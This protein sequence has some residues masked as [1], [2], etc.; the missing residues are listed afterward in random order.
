MCGIK[1]DARRVCNPLLV[2]ASSNPCSFRE[3]LY[4]ESKSVEVENEWGMLF[5]S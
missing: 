1:R 4:M 5:L 3:M 2:L